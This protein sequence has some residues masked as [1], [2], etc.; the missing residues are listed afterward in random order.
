MKRKYDVHAA[1]SEKH[2]IPGLAWNVR[3]VFK[4]GFFTFAVLMLTSSFVVYEIM[5]EPWEETFE[6]TGVD[7]LQVVGMFFTVQVTGYT[8][9]TV[10]GVIR[11]PQNLHRGDYIEVV[12]S[13]KG[14]V[15]DVE[16][17]KKRGTCNK[18][19]IY[20]NEAKCLCKID[21]EARRR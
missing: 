9:E 8:G 12:H 15:L 10:E 17:K 2:D 3:I 21:V 5:A 14:G 1:S 20:R 13:E 6:Y 18:N 19:R 16:V 4:L 7:E 11:I